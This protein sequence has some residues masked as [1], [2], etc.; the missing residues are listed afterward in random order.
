MLT[1]KRC[2]EYWEIKQLLDKYYLYV[3]KNEVYVIFENWYIGSGE[4]KI[5]K[6]IYFKEY[7][8]KYI[9]FREF[10]L[11]SID[12]VDCRIN[13][14]KSFNYDEWYDEWIFKLDRGLKINKLLNEC[15]RKNQNN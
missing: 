14:Q 4:D 12:Y 13:S 5:I 1:T 10:N 9:T 15:K 7:F 3:I 2:T 8:S 6:K 11:M